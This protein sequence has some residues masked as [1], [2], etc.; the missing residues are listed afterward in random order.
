[1]SIILERTEKLNS[2]GRTYDLFYNNKNVC[3]V[4][5]E[6]G[7]EMTQ[8]SAFIIIN[9]VFV[10]DFKMKPRK[11]IDKVSFSECSELIKE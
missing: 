8:E 7:E 9:D 10:N 3:N 6:K 4:T 2:E 1:M 11:Y 5:L